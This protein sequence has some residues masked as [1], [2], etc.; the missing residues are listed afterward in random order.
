[1]SEE[2]NAIANF[3]KE[4]AR[5]ATQEE[6]SKHR[7]ELDKR[8]AKLMKND[9]NDAPPPQ[10]GGD[11]EK[12]LPNLH[13]GVKNIINREGRGIAYFINLPAAIYAGVLYFVF[14]TFT[15]IGDAVLASIF[16]K[17]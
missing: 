1:M 2:L 7:A 11:D 9:E 12:G 10:K 3:A 16:K 13:E 17:K 14:S 4:E 6:L 15:D 5:K 8:Y